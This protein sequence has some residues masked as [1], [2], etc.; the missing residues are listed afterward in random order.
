MARVITI[1]D[2]HKLADRKGLLFISKK[3][4]GVK[5][6][7]LW[8]CKKDGYVWKANPNN[9]AKQKGCP[10][11]AGNLKYSIEFVNQY[12]Q[13]F[14]VECL[15]NFYKNAN[16]DLHYRCK[17]NHEWW[18]SFSEFKN[19]KHRCPRCARNSRIKRAVYITV[20]C[21]YCGKENS[22]PPNR[23]KNGRWKF[24][25][26][27]CRLA[28]QRKGRRPID[29]LNECKEY[30]K[31]RGGKCNSIEYKGLHDK[32]S[33]ECEKGDTWQANYSVV[34]G[35]HWCPY[36]AHTVK[37]TLDYVKQF[38]KDKYNGICHSKEYI[39]TD[40][41]MN[42]ECAQGDRFSATFHNVK[43][44]RWCSSCSKGIHE[45]LCRKNFEMVFGEKFPNSHPNW[46]KS[47]NGESLELDGYCEKLKLAFEYQ[48]KHHFKYIPYYF[49]RM[50]F[51]QRQ[52]YDQTK[53]VLCKEK[54]ITLIEIPY[55]VQPE[56]FRDYILKECIERG[57]RTPEISGT[58]FSYSE[59]YNPKRMRQLE[60][61]AKKQ[62]LR[63]LSNEYRGMGASYE[64]ECLTCGYKGRKHGQDFDGKGCYKCKKKLAGYNQRYSLEKL[65]S[66][67]IKRDIVIES[68][69]WVS[70]HSKVWFKH[71]TCGWRWIT[72]PASVK[73]GSGC[74][75]CYHN[76]PVWNKG[77]TGVMPAPWN[78]GIAMREESK[79]RLSNSLKGNIPWNKGKTGSS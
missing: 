42:F 9:I 49:K 46:L 52:D 22:V 16:Y 58:Q 40:S 6:K 63:L 25:D 55:S 75:K 79:R 2:M 61:M 76:R 17:E 20:F 28:F 65:K 14:G 4:L 57:V 24:C 37:F 1:E 5:K 64:Y 15:S 53:R 32:L 26:K 45:R 69:E 56:N 68:D 60:E 73:R 71:L 41:K 47:K 62:K 13:Q 33:W 74:P 30:A 72:T 27:Q 39:G 51:E 48:G 21:K 35:K 59:A 70:N 36:C 54:N 12:C 8:K 23:T 77:K 38:V 34:I 43:H 18:A 66:L 50:T 3:Y 67:L 10:K 31:S 44:G 78:K 7:H 19:E 29:Y 11:C